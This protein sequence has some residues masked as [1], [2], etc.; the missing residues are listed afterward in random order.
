MNNP[1]TQN[2]SP[3]E[4]IDQK[5]NILRSLFS[6]YLPIIIIALIAGII[7]SGSTYF[8][9]NSKT[10]PQLIIIS[11][12]SP[13]PSLPDLT[14]NWKTYTNTQYGAEFKYPEKY[15]N[16]RFASNLTTPKL[17]V[18]TLKEG[19]VNGCYF[20]PQFPNPTQ[21]VGTININ[22]IDFCLTYSSD[23]A[24]GQLE[25]NYYYTTFKNDNYYILKFSVKY[26]NTC[27]MYSG[28]SDQT[29]CENFIKNF[30]D[31]VEK[32]IDQILSTLKFTD[33]NQT[34]DIS[35]WKTYTNS[36]YSFQ[37]KYPSIVNLVENTDFSTWPVRGK[38]LL[39][40]SI[41]YRDQF[42]DT[43][44]VIDKENMTF[45]QN[46]GDD[47][48]Y[49]SNTNDW[50]SL[51]LNKGHISCPY[52]NA[53]NR[54]YT[55]SLMAEGAPYWELAITNKN[56]AILI[57]HHDISGH[58]DLQESSVLAGKIAS[59]FGLTGNTTELKQTCKTK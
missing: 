2:Q 54:I 27:G 8:A 29:A 26:V 42:L 16:S 52:I 3:V 10:K 14:A 25:K 37:I 5:T 30:H 17:L 24:M 48:S 40:L 1:T 44:T 20:D 19:I 55:S 7:G 6:K 31:I 50:T 11:N 39:N 38:Y 9:L 45:S 57:F 23:A 58:S 12:P 4:S 47:Y 13:T 28:L 53:L 41:D 56:Y 36:Q 51:V 43:I 35:K 33:Q 46:G 18:K 49:N 59:T 34:T 22:N 21:K 15:I 32:P